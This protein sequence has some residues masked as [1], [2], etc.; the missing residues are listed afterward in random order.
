MQRRLDFWLINSTIQE[1]VE[2]VGINPAIRTEHSAIS[3][4]INEIEETGRGPSFWNLNSSLQDHNDY[5]K[6]VT[7]KYSVW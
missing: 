3:L 5:S 4:H 2:K 6:P 7:D 1:Q